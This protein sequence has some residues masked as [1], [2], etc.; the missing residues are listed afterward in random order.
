MKTFVLSMTLLIS[1]P[2]FSASPENGEPKKVSLKEWFNKNLTYPEQA[3]KNKE[4]GIVYVSFQINEEGKA[5]S[6]EVIEGVSTSLN[7]RAIELVKNLPSDQITNNG[8][9]EGQSYILPVNF[10]LK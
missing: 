5:I 6:V 10:V 1:I 9:E 3:L 2:V 4:E 7:A 8:F